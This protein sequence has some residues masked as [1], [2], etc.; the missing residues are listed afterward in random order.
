MPPR[1][2]LR[3]RDPLDKGKA[4]RLGPAERDIE[5]AARQRTALREQD[6]AGN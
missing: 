6:V 2:R 3:G 4:L 1:L 5:P